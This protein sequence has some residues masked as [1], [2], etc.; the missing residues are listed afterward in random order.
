MLYDIASSLWTGLVALCCVSL[1]VGVGHAQAPAS[2][3]EVFRPYNGPINVPNPITT[4]HGT[5]LAGYQG[6]FMAEGDG[7]DMGFVHWGDVDHD[8]PR[9]T[10]DMWPDMSELDEDEKFD[11]NF[12][13]PDGTPAQVFSS[14]HRKTVM[15]H[16][17]W[18]QEYGIDGV[19]VQRFT[20]E[21]DPDRPESHHDLRT[22]TV[23]MHCREA[24]NTY[25]RGFAVMYDCGFN[26]KEVDEILK[27]W[28]RLVHDMKILET[29]AYMRHEGR[30]VMSLW[31]FGF[32]HRSF[33]AQAARELFEYI[34]SDEGG[35]C[36]IML[37]VPNDWR[38]W[39]REKLELLEEFGD[40]ISPWNVGRFST[41]DG[42]REHYANFFPSD[43]AY[44]EEY[45]KDYYPV[46]FPGF[47]WTNLRDGRTPLNAIPRQG[48]RFAWAQA[49]LVKEYGLDMI[50]LAMFDEV[51]E[52][53]AWFKVSNH[54]PVGMFA[55]YEGYPSDHYL[56][57]AGEIGKMMEGKPYAFPDTQPNPED[58]AYEPL[59]QLEFFK[60]ESPFSDET[61]RR[62][63]SMFAGKDI[64]LHEGPYSDW[65]VDLYNTEALDLQ[66]IG[67]DGILE[68][69][70]FG[71]SLA[72]LAAGYEDL[73]YGR[74]DTDAIARLLREHVQDGHTLLVL[75][76]GPYPAFHP[77]NGEV[78]KTFGF[79]LNFTQIVQDGEVRPAGACAESL[80]PW[81]VDRTVK[82][83][84][85]TREL[86]PDAR[87][88]RSLMKVHGP[89]GT[90]I[91]DAVSVVQPGGAFHNG[92]VI[93]VANG[94][95][96]YPDREGLLNAVLEVTHESMAK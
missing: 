12:R 44:C 60:A 84:L 9:A 95:T 21:I 13:Y 55:T 61:T 20:G 40:I 91:G 4:I 2:S 33:D 14:T 93:Y 36:T 73:A 45:G 68:K 80:E 56:R 57:I 19:W 82:S 16:F 96:R 66:P 89:D 92:T 72:V 6:W 43:I 49:E 87:S 10:V 90:Y 25:G 85:M 65:A 77:D 67:W 18:M 7:F 17:R 26:R 94:L 59:S 38:D 29:P 78:A 70:G 34:K 69:R 27:D 54:P 74:D 3:A 53:T 81:T 30:P 39:P 1:S 52:G 31:G 35:N 28:K 62:W 47:S 75:G 22:N 24:A 15:R 8:P 79:E 58:M 48:G 11:T 86:Y 51:D 37:G 42:A 41:I 46:I 5:V 71:S 23:L 76:G 64:Y 83:R 63:T 50:Y 32:G 88:Y